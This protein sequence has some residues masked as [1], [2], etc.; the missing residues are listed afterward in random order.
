MVAAQW[1]SAVSARR[2]GP[3]ATPRWQTASGTT[4][5]VQIEVSPRF[6]VTSGNRLTILD[7][8][9]GRVLWR[10]APAGYVATVFESRVYSADARG[11]VIAFDA[12]TGRTLWRTSPLCPQGDGPAAVGAVT[13]APHDVFVGCNSSGDLFRLDAR[14]GHRLAAWS[15]LSMNRFL[16]IRVLSPR[17]IAVVLDTDG[18]LLESHLVLLRRTDLHQLIAELPESSIA[19]VV[20]GK[21]VI[22]DACC[23]GNFD[24]PVKLRYYD[25]R[26]G[27]LS[28][29]LPLPPGSDAL[30]GFAASLAILRG[31]L[32]VSMPPD[33]EDYGDPL[34]PSRRPKR[35]V[36]ELVEP[37]T[38]IA[39][40]H[41]LVR[42]HG[43]GNA[44]T[45]ELI[46]LRTSPPRTQWRGD[47]G[48]TAYDERSAP[49]IV[50]IGY[51]GSHRSGSYFVVAHDGSVIATR[52][53]CGYIAS[54][55]DR[56]V[57]QC[58][59]HALGF[60]TLEA[61]AIESGMR[62]EAILRRRLPDRPTP[63]LCGG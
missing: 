40:G 2:A 13:A 49:D 42:R 47:D 48:I 22:N 62:P 51:I 29:D 56:F 27:A 41:A 21:A 31:H 28:D 30:P 60:D 63:M 36:T 15:Y 25:L 1:P 57:A 53:A 10:H 16:E 20:G 11:G 46:D 12:L 9:T 50:P 61:F 55:G 52:D 45:L 14:S 58:A 38:F 33:I 7:A 54:A 59:P 35:I 39:G 19:G 34:A 17:V 32:F 6:V 43:G 44:R 26:A 23:H 24:G 4:G 8:K 37:A 18:A 3:V 5:V